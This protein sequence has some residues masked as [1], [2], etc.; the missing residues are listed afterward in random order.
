MTNDRVSK[1]SRKALFSSYSIAIMEVLSFVRKV[2]TFPK[3][4]FA[5][6]FVDMKSTNT[7]R[8]RIFNS[9]LYF[10]FAII[11]TEIEHGITIK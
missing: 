6:F 10:V 3:D 1:L 9:R 5:N 7:T 2:Q 11:V 8:K 4:R